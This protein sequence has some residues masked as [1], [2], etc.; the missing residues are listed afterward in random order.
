VTGAAGFAGHH[1]LDHVL[2]ATDWDIVAAASFRHRGKS[3]RITAVT[4][5]RPGTASRVDVL[6]HDLT[7]PFSSQSLRRIYGVDGLDYLVAYAAE[8]HVDRSL[9]D[10]VPFARNNSD[11]M[12][13]TLEAARQ[14]RPRAIVLVSTDEVYGPEPETGPHPEWAP[15]L[16]SN[17]YAGSKAAAE[18]LAI[19]YWRSYGIPLIIVNCVNLA[20]ERQDAE[21]YIPMLIRSA[22]RSELVTVH[23]TPGDIGTRCYL[24]ARNLASGICFLLNGAPPALFPLHA[25]PGAPQAYR[26][27][28]FNITGPDRVS[29]LELAETVAAITGRPLRYRLMNA[30]SSR[31]GHDLHYGLDGSKMTALG[32]KPPVPFAESLER[33]VRWSLANTQWLADD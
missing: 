5:G 6:T 33:T 26:P 30:H 15:I 21:K 13:S 7:A 2:A 3:D 1:F 22:S 28:R 23:G 19:S 11:V 14:L 4:A 25:A 12:L 31:P 16:P 29:N 24:H 27:D 18:A 17:P 10:P 9:A 8:S 32:W 20:G